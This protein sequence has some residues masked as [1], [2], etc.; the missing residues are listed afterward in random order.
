MMDFIKGMPVSHLVS[1]ELLLFKF[2]SRLNTCSI[3][4]FYFNFICH[5]NLHS[6]LLHK[7]HKGKD[8]VL[9]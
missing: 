6:M 3:F 7:F 8:N 9:I 5:T 2:L 4:F 1:L